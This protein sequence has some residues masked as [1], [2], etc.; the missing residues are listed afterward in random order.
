MK[1][2]CFYC[3]KETSIHIEFIENEPS[4][5]DCFDDLYCEYQELLKGDDLF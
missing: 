4:C 2:K 3:K 1:E 5:K